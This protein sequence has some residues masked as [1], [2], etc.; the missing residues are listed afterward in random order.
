MKKVNFLTEYEKHI[1]SEYAKRI[2][3]LNF[4]FRFYLWIRHNYV[5]DILFKHSLDHLFEIVEQYKEGRTS[6]RCQIEIGIMIT[7]KEQWLESQLVSFSQMLE[8]EE[9]SSE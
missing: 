2:S 8:K 6:V 1:K 5:Q 7:I 3:E 9:I 4:M